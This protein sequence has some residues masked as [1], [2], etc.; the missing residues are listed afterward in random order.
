MFER[1]RLL[2]KETETLPER[3]SHK[4]GSFRCLIR[5]SLL[6]FDRPPAKSM[7][8]YALGTRRYEGRLQMLVVIV[9]G[10]RH[11]VRSAR[12]SSS[13]ENPEYPRLSFSWEGRGKLD[14]VQVEVAPGSKGIY[15]PN[16]GTWR[17][18]FTGSAAELAA[19]PKSLKGLEALG[20]VTIDWQIDFNQQAQMLLD[21]SG[22][23]DFVQALVPQQ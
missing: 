7:L 1:I 8:G 4:V 22:L 11:T 23:A 12:I 3:G 10:I 9:G 21:D 17:G 14:Q 20:G 2:A 18:R 16:G 5:G 15:V 13:D 6:Y 19:L